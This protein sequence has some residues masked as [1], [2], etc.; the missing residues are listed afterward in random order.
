M[1][2]DL[3]V[4]LIV[5]TLLLVLEGTVPFYLGRRHRLR[6]GLRNG[7]LAL[8]N[9][10]IGVLLAPLLVL[11]AESSSQYQLGLL[12]QFTMPGIGG[13]VLAGV[14]T[15]VLF[16]L[17]MYGWHRANHRIP[18]LWRFHQV[19]HTDT[20]M[21]V[22]TALR[23]HPGEFLISSLLNPIVVFLL[24][25]GLVQLTLYKA[26]MLAVILVH[27]SNVAL[28]ARLER[29]LRALIVPPSM[30]RVHHSRVPGETNS[31][32]G[33]LFSFWDRLF[34]SFRLR[35]NL[36][37]VQFGTG[38]HDEDEWQPVPKLLQLPLTQTRVPGPPAQ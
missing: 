30:H 6:H 25:I 36:T 24:G 35:S 12:H 20:A 37:A 9:A 23:F 10:G 19:H 15:I 8:L 18:L 3:I 38:R 26:L 32:Y 33:S 28:P 22:T 34:G 4:G 13:A 5:L 21:D 1:T 14:L 17:W 27:H 7:S 29:S 31:N 16:D 11:A 2:P